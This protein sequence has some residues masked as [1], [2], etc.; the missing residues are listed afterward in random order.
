MNSKSHTLPFESTSPSKLA[1][2]VVFIG[3]V[4]TWL[5]LATASPTVAFLDH[6]A[7]AKEVVNK[8]VAEDYEGIRRNFN[9]TMKAG[10]SAEKMK[11]VWRSVL[12]HVGAFRSQGDPQSQMNQGWEI[13][14]IQC[15]MERGKINVEVDYDPSGKIGGL[16][17]RPAQ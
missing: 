15:Q 8:L 13:I 17:I 12:E 3:T 4:F 1:C 6:T 14:V 16:W 11:E 9:D 7:D 5:T 2:L 10:L